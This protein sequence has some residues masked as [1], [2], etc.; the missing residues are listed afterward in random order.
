MR[1]RGLVS[2]RLPILHRL[3]LEPTVPATIKAN[4]ADRLRHLPSNSTTKSDSRRVE[5]EDKYFD[6]I[7]YIFDGV[8]ML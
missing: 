7:H 4:S 2:E 6:I 8:G 1:R 3:H 5:N